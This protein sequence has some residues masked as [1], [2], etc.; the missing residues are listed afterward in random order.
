MNDE[1]APDP[2]GTATPTVTTSP[3][4]TNYLSLVLRYLWLVLL[5]TAVGGGVAYYYGEQQE[6]VFEATSLVLYE[7]QTPQLLSDVAPVVQAS[8]GNNYW[9]KREFMETQL[10][11]LRSTDLAGLV[12]DRLGLDSDV[13]F[14][15]LHQIEDPAELER[16]LESIDPARV[17]RQALTVQPVDD[18][19]LIKIRARAYD[20][21]LAATIANTMAEVY[22]EQDLERQL[23][24]SDSAMEW[25]DE[26]YLALRTQL[27]A[28]DNALVQFLDEH[29]LI[30]VTLEEHVGL[31]QMMFATSD[32]LVNARRERDRHQALAR[33]VETIL[34]HQRWDD[35]DVHAIIDNP[36][37]QQVKSGLFSLE[38]SEA[39]LTAR[40][41]LE[42]HPEMRSVSERIQLA[43]ERLERETRAVLSSHL[44]EAREAELAVRR[45][46][47]QLS[48]VE[49]R[50]RSLGRHE[51]EYAQLQR[52][53]EVAR[54]LFAMI[55]RRRE[56][57]ALTRN[58]L[59]SAV[60]VLERANP[61]SSPVAPNRLVILL[62]GLVGGFS[63]G[64][65]I[66]LLI[67]MSD[68]S[69][70]NH[71]QLERDY[72][73]TLLGFFPSIR[74]SAG[75]EASA[76]GPARGQKWNND[77]YVHDFPK[78]QVAESCR[79][80]RTNLSFLGTSGPLHTLLITSPGPREGKTTT[81]LNMG[82]AI[83]QTGV[84]VLVIDADLRRPRIHNSFGMESNRGLSTLLIEDVSPDDVIQRSQIENVDVLVSGPIPPNP[85]ELLGSQRFL[86]VMDQLKE[87][88]DQII[89]DSPPVAPVTDAVLMSSRIDGV[90][91]V[92][93][94]HKT[95]RMV[96]GRTVE[97]LNAV[98]A[99]VIGAVLN[100]FDVRRR[101]GGQYYYYHRYYGAYYGEDA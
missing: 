96:L 92:V 9:A 55:E 4:P 79:T 20:P 44:A 81:A 100:D 45:L 67:E 38:A 54:D 56:E 23:T 24:S 1:F 73:L 82:A 49:Q 15:G 43:E 59:H 93:R 25:L 2:T 95:Q 29:D 30:A 83:A 51:I 21:E 88:Y 47:A 64:A 61:S 76:A 11:L 31:S 86:D 57:V 3:L 16:R 40:G 91:L 42:N 50:V 26:K 37:I 36:L 90:V 8:P 63:V 7:D 17:L 22:R 27:E 65:V 53:A 94:A 46:E 12:V 75:T 18:S 39:D 41:Y 35:A 84:R 66:A 13:Q 5:C 74:P 101:G 77:T 60:D 10:R 71:V 34:E 68:S 69:L 85:A 14:L 72:G 19:T 6:E 87:R 98:E 62:L 28:S 32:L 89:V 52:E 80:I 48:D 78:S 99:N 58:S 33:R 97:Q 70:K